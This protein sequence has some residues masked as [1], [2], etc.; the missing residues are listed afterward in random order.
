MDTPPAFVPAL[1]L[2]ELVSRDDDTAV[3]PRQPS[4]NPGL[5]PAF[6][7]EGRQ[8]HRAHPKP[9]SVPSPRPLPAGPAEKLVELFRQTPLGRFL[10]QLSAHQRQD[11]LQGYLRDFL[12]LTTRVSTQEELEVGPGMRA[13]RA[14]ATSTGGQRGSSSSASRAVML[15]RNVGSEDRDVRKCPPPGGTLRA[16]RS[17]HCPAPR[18]TRSLY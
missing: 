17:S 1:P 10:A 6:R 9:L 18:K 2:G 8:G 12:L 5:V 4:Q 11:L 14:G 7:V 16:G 13:P 3:T 15:E